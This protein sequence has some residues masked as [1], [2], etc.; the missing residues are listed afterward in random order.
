MAHRIAV[1]LAK[2]T[3]RN[4]TLAAFGSWG[5]NPEQRLR[6]LFDGVYSDGARGGG[7]AVPADH[8]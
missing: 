6:E 8:N 5:G 4:G 1:T 2:L 7:S 3:D